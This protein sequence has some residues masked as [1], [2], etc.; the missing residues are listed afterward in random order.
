MKTVEIRSTSKALGVLRESELLLI[1]LQVSISSSSKNIV[2]G[3]GLKG[4]FRKT[5]KVI[6]FRIIICWLIMAQKRVTAL[7]CFIG[8]CWSRMFQ[9]TR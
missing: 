5:K 7:G 1:H 2:I 6:Y 9:T 4:Y 8:T 3:T